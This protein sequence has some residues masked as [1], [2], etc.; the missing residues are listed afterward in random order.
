MDN[1][2]VDQCMGIFNS[3]EAMHS[4]KWVKYSEPKKPKDPL[5]EAW[6]Y[7][8]N[9]SSTFISAKFKMIFPDIP[10]DIILETLDATVRS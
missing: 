1:T 8:S 2:Y 4:D 9:Q 6:K 3:D 5:V 7:K 10:P